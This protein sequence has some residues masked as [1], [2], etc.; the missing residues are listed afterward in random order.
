MT[1]QIKLF[2]PII[3]NNELNILNKTLKSKFWADGSGSNQVQKFEEELGEEQA[4]YTGNR[5]SFGN[6]YNCE[7]PGNM[8][9]KCEEIQATYKRCN[10]T[11]LYT[12]FNITSKR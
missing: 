4:W 6:C 7:K 12:Y 3:D 8:A 2:V 9:H 5:A 1:K 10:V 11:F